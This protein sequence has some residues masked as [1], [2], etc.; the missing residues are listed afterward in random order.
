M[1]D[2]KLTG[3][4]LEWQ[5][6]TGI[7]PIA[8]TE[9]SGANGIEVSKD[10]ETLYVAAWGSQELVRFAHIHGAIQ[11]TV[12]KVGFSPDNLRWAP[13]GK[14]L[15]AGQNKSASTTGG[16]PGFKGWTVAKLDPKTMKV[17]EILKDGGESPLQ[18]AS[19]A[20]ETDGT[21]WIG[22][23]SGNRIAYKPLKLQ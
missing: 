13:D 21:L 10:G 14:I 17:T 18:N 15:V 9:L 7:K 2:H 22:P 1:M 16:F 12:V 19:V 3:G 11:K 4:V 5:N 8:G 23:F 6:E 20:I